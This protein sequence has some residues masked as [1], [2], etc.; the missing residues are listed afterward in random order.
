MHFQILKSICCSTLLLLFAGCASA[1][2]HQLSAIA[3][4]DRGDPANALTELQ[5]AADQRGAETEIIA[6]DLA[7]AELMSG[8]ASAAE[9]RL[10][11]SRRKIDFLRQ[12]DFREQTTA[13]LTDDK[14]VAWSAREFEQRMIDNLLTLTSIVGNRQDAFAYASQGMEHASQDRMLIKPEPVQDHSIVTVGHESEQRPHSPPPARF[15]PNSLTAY[16]SAAV[17]SE[18]PLN[19]EVMDKAVADVSFWHS[20]GS[21][22]VASQHS[23]GAP[24]MTGFGVHSTA[25]HGVLHVV[26]LVGRVT[27]WQP[28]V[29]APTSAALLLAD[30]ILSAVGDHTL[31][32]TIAPVR[33]ARP[34]QQDTTDPFE[35][36]VTVNT[37][38]LTA[39]AFSRPLL[40]LNRAAWNSYEEDRDKQIARAVARRIVKKGTVY[41]AKNQLGVTND[42]GVDL[43]LNLGGVAWEA[44]EKPD[45]RHISLLPARVD[46]L[47][48]EL[49]EGTHTLTLGTSLSGRPTISPRS[50]TTVA[51]E[52][53]KNTFVLCFRTGNSISA[54]VS[55]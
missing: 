21:K 48:M 50:T 54:I 37:E 24:L 28:E 4:I 12:K 3:M 27:Y 42:S 26:T 49:P 46:V 11:D 10:N 55:R 31:P 22:A 17:H 2:K 14:A 13:V 53:G 32:P 16:L 34:C 39:T 19:A 40:D 44:L 33:I 8:N 1:Q 45:T 43:L 6:V 20:P 9:S 5:K 41:A 23:S 18:I 36:L 29:A 35:T 51:I 7:I 38:Q 25:G 47:Q 30:Q 15:E 52:N